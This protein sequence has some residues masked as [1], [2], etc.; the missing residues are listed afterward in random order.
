MDKSLEEIVNQ[1]IKKGDDIV[2]RAAIDILKALYILYGSA[3]ESE[4]KDVLRG[5][6]SIR[7]LDLSEMWEI[8]KVIP[9]A[10]EILNKLNVIKVEEKLRADLGK[11]K[12]IKERFY[13]VNK[14][15][16]LLRIFSSDREIDRYRYEVSGVI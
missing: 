10:A 9:K 4:L 5:L 6:W 11:S 8:E 15:T 13:E 1:L 14:L 16:V 3:W 7:G 2:Y 12:P